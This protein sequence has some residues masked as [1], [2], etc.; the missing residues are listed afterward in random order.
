MQANIIAAEYLQN[1]SSDP[2]CLIHYARLIDT[3][4]S[5]SSPVHGGWREKIPCV[6]HSVDCLALNCY[7]VIPTFRL[8]L[9]VQVCHKDVP[10]SLGRKPAGLLSLLPCLSGSQRSNS[11]SSRLCS[12]EK[13]QDWI[14][15]WWRKDG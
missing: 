14:V 10:C 8:G 4:S 15:F 5:H 9:E 13:C 6:F 1:I 3:L 11:R 12:K 7:C 2:R